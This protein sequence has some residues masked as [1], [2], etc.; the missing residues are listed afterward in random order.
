[1]MITETKAVITRLPLVA[2]ARLG[3]LIS[4]AVAINLMTV[5]YAQQTHGY[6]VTATMPQPRDTFVQGLQI[7][8]G[9]LYVGTGQYGKSRLLRYNMA[10][11]TLDSEKL[12]DRS[13]FGEGITVLNDK[14][15]QL[16]WKSR[17]ALVYNKTDFKGINW[18]RLPGEGW[19]ITNNTKMLIYSD[20]SDKLHFLS[21][22]T[23]RISHSI[24]VSE[25]GKNINHLNELEW[26]NGKIWANIWTSNRI[27]IID[28]DSGNITASVDLAGLLP[29]NERRP[30]TD[31]LNGIAQNLDDG[32]IWV[33]GKYWPRLYQIEL[34]PPLPELP[35]DPL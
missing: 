10:D 19:G 16:T 11:G 3:L 30:N 21:P 20:G 25:N 14:I 2:W 23:L 9:Q 5:A 12:L 24:T 1:M 22:Q 33:T 13:L 27:V 6:K 31:V 35:R 17:I 32:T 4:L 7:V 8:D 29:D 28:P 15:Y 18:F 26:I 34:V